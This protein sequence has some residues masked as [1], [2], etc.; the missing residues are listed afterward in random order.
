MATLFTG[1]Y[2]PGAFIFFFVFLDESAG[3]LNSI[4][5]KEEKQ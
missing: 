4:K 3:F 2:S 1:I 5:K